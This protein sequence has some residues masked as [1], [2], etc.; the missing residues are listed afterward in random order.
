MFD[1][2]FKMSRKSGMVNFILKRLY[3][4][5]IPRKVNF[6]GEEQCFISA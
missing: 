3:A 5:D 2:L 4:C 6:L 1:S